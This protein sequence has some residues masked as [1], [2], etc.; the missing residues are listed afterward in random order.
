VQSG[1]AA[2]SLLFEPK[3]GKSRD[4]K[5]ILLDLNLPGINGTKVIDQIR[6]NPLTQTIPVVMLTSSKRDEDIQSSYSKGVNS[7][8]CKPVDF[9]EFVELAKTL[10][11]YWTDI[12]EV[13]LG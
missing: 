5:V 1:E 13:S 3:H 12:N 9:K 8:V 11:L 7:Y 6:H 10:K 2:L 4:W